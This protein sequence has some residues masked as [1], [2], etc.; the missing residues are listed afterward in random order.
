LQIETDEGDNFHVQPD[1]RVNDEFGQIAYESF[2][3]FLREVRAG[4]VIFER[5]LHGFSVECFP[6]TCELNPGAPTRVDLADKTV[7]YLRSD[8]TVS[9]D[10]D[11][12]GYLGWATLNDFFVDVPQD[13]VLSGD[14]FS[15]ECW[16]S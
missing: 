8:G 12:V 1:G 2:T 13:F 7:L 16:T 3:A 15:I 5:G 9:T 14:G 6:Q 11:D 4:F 10:L